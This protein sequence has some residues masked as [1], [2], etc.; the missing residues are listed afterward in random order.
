MAQADLDPSSVPVG[1]FSFAHDYPKSWGS[2]SHTLHFP[3]RVSCIACSPHP[4]RY[5]AVTSGSDIQV[6]DLYTV[7]L[8]ETLHGH[9]KDVHV[10][11]FLNKNV[12]V[13]SDGARPSTVIV[14][15]LDDDGKNTS[16]SE[17]MQIDVRGLAEVAADAVLGGLREGVD[18]GGGLDQQD[19][20]NLVTALNPAIASFQR[21]YLRRRELSFEGQLLGF[22][23]DPW[24]R[25]ADLQ[26]ESKPNP[27]ALLVYKS[28]DHNNV[29]HISQLVPNISK[30]GE[31]APEPSNSLKTYRPLPQ[32]QATDNVIWAGFSPNNKMLA[33]V[34]WDQYARI[35][36]T[37]SLDT[38]QPDLTPFELLYKIGPTGGQTWVGAWH[39]SSEY[40]A[41]SQGSPQTVVYV[42]RIPQRDQSRS[43]STHPELIHTQ[44]EFSGWCRSLAWSPDGETLLCA[45]R[46]KVLL[47]DPFTGAIDRNFSSAPEAEITDESRSL[48]QARRLSRFVECGNAQWTSQNRFLWTTGDGAIELFDRHKELRYRWEPKEADERGMGSSHVVVASGKLIAADGDTVRIWDVPG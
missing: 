40:F 34:S 47:Y 41:F 2:E 18:S 7:Q 22:G 27:S 24:F 26:S 35:Y 3:Q 46:N 17:T 32:D 13:S 10:V 30:V 31:K 37:P 12:L 11:S 23:S 39:P 48:K 36:A 15:R 9:E 8:I 4:Y 25:P 6:F 29:V 38:D 42:Y 45:A 44:P 20:A 33:I 21:Q 16:N 28:G 43:G 1:T 14:W 5:L 19:R